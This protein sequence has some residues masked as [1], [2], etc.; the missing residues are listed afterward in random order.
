MLLFLLAG[1]SLLPCRGF[2]AV[3]SDLGL[4][5]TSVVRALLLVF[6]VLSVPEVLPP[7]GMPALVEDEAVLLLLLFLLTA[8]S[9]LELVLTSAL[10]IVLG[11][12]TL[13][14]FAV[15]EFPEPPLPLP[16]VADL[17]DAGVL[18]DLS[19]PLF[20]FTPLLAVVL[21][22][23]FVVLSV[24]ELVVVMVLLAGFVVLTVPEFPELVFPAPF[25]DFGKVVVE[26]ELPEFPLAVLTL[27]L[28]VVLLPPPAA[29]GFKIEENSDFRVWY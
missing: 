2:A 22:A 29:C 9:D 28:V 14:L 6:T 24:E 1:F 19:I 15:P 12:F 16:A 10:L 4:V 5:L 23:V 27:A 26:F 13:V 3:L 20:P 7:L 17:V 25:A 21:F 8:T 11:V 18:F